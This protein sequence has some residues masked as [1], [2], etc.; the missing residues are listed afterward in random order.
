MSLRARLKQA[1]LRPR[2][3][4]PGVYHRFWH[5]HD[6][7]PAR[8]HLRLYEDGTG[9]LILNAATVLHLNQTAAEYAW[10]F[11]MNHTADQAAA[12]M[13]ARY[14]IRRQDARQDYLTFVQRLETLL[15]NRDVD[16]VFTWGFER[17]TPAETALPAPLRLDCALTYQLPPT[18]S[19]DW[20]PQGRARRELSTEEWQRVLQTAWDFGIPHVT[21]TGGEPTL[22][23]DLPKL[24]TWSENLGQV[25]GLLT[26]GLR[27]REAAYR[28][29]LLLSGLDHVLIL[30]QPKQEASWQALASIT[31]EDI[32]TTVHLTL[33]P[34]IAD[35]SAPL[36]E[37]LAALGVNALSLS[38]SDPALRPALERA[39]ELAASLGLTLTWDLPVPYS[40]LNP[41]ALELAAEDEK[42]STARNSL[43]VEPDGD[44]LP[45]QG[46][47]EQ[48]LGNCLQTD[49]ATL[50]QKAREQTA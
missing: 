13:A 32:H 27:L 37:R 30:L 39:R 29:D 45:A 28:R 35:E 12:Q 48:V 6:V 40:A 44:V 50:W 2:G 16:P 10:H 25:T 24:I 21:F 33:T 18:A 42:P 46:M 34:D 36:L 22:R 26:D 17:I 8:V 1:L 23:A 49:W 4:S 11:V 14:R 3:P 31:P 7:P 38:A 20:A 43:Y 19:P 9:L 47:A 41:V 5:P 15:T